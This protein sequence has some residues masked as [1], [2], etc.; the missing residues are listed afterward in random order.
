MSSLK[1]KDC[2]SK[3]IGLLL[4]VF[5]FSSLNH[6]VV[7]Q[8]YRN[9]KQKRLKIYYKKVKPGQYK[10]YAQNKNY[11]PYQIKLSFTKLKN[12]NVNTQVPY[13]GVVD[14]RVN[15]QYL[16]TA[17][18]ERNKQYGFKYKYK[19]LLG[20]PKNAWPDGHAYLFP[21]QH[22]EKHKVTQGYNGDYSHHDKLALDFE[23]KR[24]TP[25]TAARSGI[26][27]QVKE[28]SNIGGT[29]K[30]Y[31]D[32]ANY[33]T[34]Y[35]N[36]GTFA[37][38]AHLKYNGARVRIGDK[39]DAGEVIGYSGDTG[40]SRGPHLHFEVLKPV[41]MGRETIATDFLNHH[42]QRITARAGNYYYSYHPGSNDYKVELGSKLTNEDYEDYS[43]P[44]SK[45]NQ[46][47]LTTKKVD[48]TVV[49]FV[50]NGY[51]KDVRIKIK[52]KKTKNI[53]TSKTVPFSTVV[54]PTT[55]VYAFLIKPDNPHQPWDYSIQYS[56]T[57]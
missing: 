5:L 38:Y 3:I 54:P 43:K 23:M 44:V 21:Y 35:H 52:F 30:R 45:T 6:V 29:N 14:P 55:K 12:M 50:K 40:W 46:L 18:A 9:Q 36:D 34:I 32:D 7:A 27:V 42:Q 20:N 16:F 49:L 8:N 13:Y 56:Y 11:A 1:T 37:E 2:K 48:D 22:G 25:V 4:L 33:I 26:V 17:T 31:L 10:F 39:I 57:K 24:G 15:K 51:E 41:R 53:K 19:C 28:D 47:D